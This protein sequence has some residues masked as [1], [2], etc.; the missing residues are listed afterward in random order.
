M[1]LRLKVADQ[2]AWL[3]VALEVSRHCKT[4]WS[5]AR[6]LQALTGLYAH[7]GDLRRAAE[8]SEQHFELV[9]TAKECDNRE[10]ALGNLGNMLA[11]VGNHA[12]AK[13]VFEQL[14]RSAR[15]QTDKR[16]EASALVSLGA[17]EQCTGDIQAAVS[18]VNE[19]LAIYIDR[20]DYEGGA[21]ALASLGNAHLRQNNPEMAMGCFMQALKLCDAL[22][23]QD[24]AAKMH[25]HIALLFEQQGRHEQAIQLME[26]AAALLESRGLS[27]A[28]LAR[29]ILATWQNEMPPDSSSET[30]PTHP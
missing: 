21:A 13:A 14:L 6:A 5:E 2:I 8:F 22:G 26:G 10:S 1:S 4:H 19:A 12:A 24:S 18:H 15:E 23:D 30:Q 9:S 11:D 29:Q 16:R 28:A 20:K 7:I 17:V 27:L 3:E 25:Y